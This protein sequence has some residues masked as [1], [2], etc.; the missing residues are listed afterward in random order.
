MAKHGS[1]A[2]LLAFATCC[3][4]AVEVTVPYVAAGKSAEAAVLDPIVDAKAFAPASDPSKNVVVLV[5]TIEPADTLSMVTSTLYELND[6]LIVLINCKTPE[7]FRQCDY[8]V[9]LTTF[10]KLKRLH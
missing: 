4:V 9:S 8:M 2:Y 1:G 3:T 7:E 5:T 6:A 10:A